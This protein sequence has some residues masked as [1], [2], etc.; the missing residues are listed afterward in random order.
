MGSCVNVGVTESVKAKDGEKEWM[1]ENMGKSVN[2]SDCILI[3]L[4]CAYTHTH[5]LS[6][7][8]KLIH[9]LY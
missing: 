4:A 3:L 5:F 6:H 1:K 8:S 7:G 9:I 2:Y